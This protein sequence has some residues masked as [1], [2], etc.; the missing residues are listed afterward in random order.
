MN[1]RMFFDREQGNVR[2]TP[3]TWG[4]ALEINDPGILQKLREMNAKASAEQ[5]ATLGDSLAYALLNLFNEGIKPY[6]RGTGPSGVLW[7]WEGVFGMRPLTLDEQELKMSQEWHAEF[8]RVR[9]EEGKRFKIAEDIR[10][11]PP[12]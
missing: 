1:Y 9:A 3:V 7:H 10:A 8:E 5:W 6:E 4:A 2:L 12:N 11:C